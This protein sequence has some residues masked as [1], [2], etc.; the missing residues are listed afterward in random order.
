[1][2]D[3]ISE[4]YG[5]TECDNNF[6]IAPNRRKVYIFSLNME[7]GLF[8]SLDPVN[9][10]YG[11]VPMGRSLNRVYG[12]SAHSEFICAETQDAFFFTM[13]RIPLN[14]WAE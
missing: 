1:V 4:Y 6:Y 13:C 12:S 14:N 8:S 5:R 9:L 11:T 10:L 7:Q 3:F 2:K